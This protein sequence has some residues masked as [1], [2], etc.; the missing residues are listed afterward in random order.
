M[1]YFEDLTEGV[2]IDLGQV[3]VTADEIIEF[4]TRYDPQPFHV[5]P[6]RAKESLFGGLIASGWHTAVLYMRLL[7]DGLLNDTASMGSPGLDGLRW[8]EPVRPGDTLRARFTPVERRRSQSRP[9]VGI[10][11]GHGEAWNQHDTLVMTV[12]S[13]GFFG[14]RGADGA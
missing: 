2:G 1:R 11:R 9:G 6:E 7:A 14:C 3:R 4:A 13:V 10:I 8:L 12:D 5:D